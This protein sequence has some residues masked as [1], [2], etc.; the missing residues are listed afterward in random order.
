MFMA[1][2]IQPLLLF[3]AVFMT[4]SLWAEETSSAQSESSEQSLLL[5]SLLEYTDK[6][7]CHVKIAG[8]DGIFAIIPM[9][10]AAHSF[11]ENNQTEIMVALHTTL[12]H[13]CDISEPDQAGL[14]PL[15][16]A[17]LFH[18]LVMVRYLLQQGADPYL[19]IHRPD[20]PVDGLNSF[21]FL[22]QIK[23]AEQLKKTLQAPRD[24]SAIEA[25]LNLYR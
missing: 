18:D 22:Q 2:N 19:P 16:A 1:K 9:L 7:E 6:Q 17:I 15:N 23:K 20:S 3:L 12:N 11:P 13:G 21:E 4:T 5:D 14:Q 10:V 8:R 25:V 24:F